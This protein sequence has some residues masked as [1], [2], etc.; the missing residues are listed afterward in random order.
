MKT[1]ISIFAGLIILVAMIGM[2]PSFA[3]SN[4]IVL[5]TTDGVQLTQTVVPM[6]I[7]S[8]NVMPWGFIEGTIENH[9]EGF[10]VIV[11]IYQNDEPVHFAQ[12]TVNEDGT[13]EYKFRARNVDGNNVVNVYEGDYEVK[14]F[15]SIQI[16]GK[17]LI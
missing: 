6:S 8:D 7:S 15:K 17:N 10:P 11:Q 16:T 14:I 9:A 13:Y 3:D 4:T 12:T 2:S 1:K 5:S